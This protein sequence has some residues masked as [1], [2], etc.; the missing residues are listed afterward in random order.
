MTTT[1]NG[2]QFKSLLGGGGSA[3]VWLALQLSLERPVAIKVLSYDLM[4]DAS[5]QQ[6]FAHESRLIAR[7]NHPNIVQV[8]EQG[9]TDQGQPYFVM[10]YIKSIALS[11]VMARQD[12]AIARKLDILI[13]L[14]A[15]LTYAH[16]NGVIHRDIKPAN[17]LVDYEGHVRLVDF[18]IA[19][20][21]D[22]GRDVIAGTQ[23]YMAPEQAQGISQ[24]SHKSD[25]YSFGLLMHQLLYGISPGAEHASQTI[26]RLHESQP[27]LRA[28]YPVIQQCLEPDP[29]HRPDSA[30]AIR[31]TLLLCAAGKHLANNRWG[32][33]SE[34]DQL[35]S[36]YTLLDVLKENPVSSTYLVN[37]PNKARLLVIKKQPANQQDR[38]ARSAAKLTQIRH[39]HIARLFGTGKNHRVLITVTEYLP[40]G[41]LADRLSQ[42]IAP[43]QWQVLA[44]QLFSALACA[45]SYGLIHGNLR[46]GNIMFASDDQL[47]LCDFGFAPHRDGPSP[48]QPDEPQSPGADLYSAG[49]VLFEAL[50]GHLP[51]GGW[52]RLR[53]RW[54]LRRHK[55]L[56]PLL[57]A[58]LH[59]R[60]S[61]RPASA[62]EVADALRHPVA[63]QQTIVSG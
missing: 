17:V 56:R 19:G 62:G 52:L 35:P 9:K 32:I 18:G 37:D 26:D 40:A 45:H 14:A 59:P 49:A 20:F 10:P 47:K 7:L 33:E 6:L 27:R 57:L 38:A 50:T 12:V 48:Y 63:E 24:T 11:A 44:W 31:E 53:D 25:L 36:N 5:C 3:Q 2:Y 30:L 29:T 1:I 8:I 4:D 46:P 54:R 43:A 42:T 58:L 55:N 61:K 60:A 41:S 23:A 15:A 34:R 22:L 16:R 13:Q 28:L 21:F 51:S 39:P